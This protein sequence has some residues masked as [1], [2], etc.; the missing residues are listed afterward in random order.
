MYFEPRIA[1]HSRLHG[2]PFQIYTFV[3][4]YFRHLNLK[5][6]LTETSFHKFYL[7]FSCSKEFMGWQASKIEWADTT[8]QAQCSSTYA[9]SLLPTLALY[10]SRVAMV[11][12]SIEHLYNAL[13]ARLFYTHCP[14][15]PLQVQ[16]MTQ[17]TSSLKKISI[18]SLNT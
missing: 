17:I 4:L 14:V 10:D 16:L 11:Q 7:F 13:K 8:N 15:V 12:M 1:T 5:F 9:G 18:S 3:I 6:N 2:F